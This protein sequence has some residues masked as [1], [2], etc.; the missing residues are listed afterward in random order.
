MPRRLRR[1][2]PRRSKRGVRPPD[3]D[4]EAIRMRHH[5]HRDI[6]SIVFGEIQS[7]LFSAGET[8]SD[9]FSALPEIQS[10]LFSM[11]APV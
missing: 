4:H 9:L 5:D 7:D 8:Q 1:L 2:R 6:A 11:G 3:T 10:D